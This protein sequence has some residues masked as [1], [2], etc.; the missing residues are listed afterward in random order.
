MMKRH[1]F[2]T[3]IATQYH[4]RSILWIVFLLTMSPSISFA[5]TDDSDADQ[6]SSDTTSGQAL[7]T[8]PI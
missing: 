2:R 1:E 7:T 6:D 5:G 4:F 8:A 3:L